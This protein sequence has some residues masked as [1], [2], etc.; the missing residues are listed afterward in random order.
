LLLS[1][2]R[3]LGG[4]TGASQHLAHGF[5]TSTAAKVPHCSSI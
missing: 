2:H 4:T 1:G 3:M 5:K